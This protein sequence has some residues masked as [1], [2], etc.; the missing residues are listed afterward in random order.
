MSTITLEAALHPAQEAVWTSN[1]RF[2]VV[3]C[4]RRFGKT[5]LAVLEVIHHAVNLHGAEVWWVSPTHDQSDIA[6]RMFKAAV[7]Q[8]LVVLNETKRLAIFRHNGSRV[9]FK[10]A[11]RD[12]N[13]RGE[14]LTFLVLDEAAFIK[15][16]AW[17]GSLLPS[18][19]DRRGSALLIGTFDG[20]ENWFYVEYMR[21]QDPS[22]LA[23]DSWRFPTSANPYISLDEIEAARKRMPSDQFAQEFLADPLAKRGAVFPGHYVQAAIE[24]GRPVK[25][26]PA[27]PKYAGL[28]WGYAN[29]TVFEVCQESTESHVDWIDERSWVT[30]QL[31]VRV[32]VIVELVK[33]YNVLTV[34]ADAAGASE[35]AKLLAA[36]EAEGL[37]TTLLRVPFGKKVGQKGETL[38]EAGI[39]TRRWYL[40]NDLESLGMK[41]PE[42]QRTTLLYH[43]KE[44]KLSSGRTVSTE[45]IEKHDDHP[46]DAA[47]CFYASRRHQIIEE[48]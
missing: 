14:G 28:D 15:E 43:Y 42:L 8:S 44:V 45:D 47:T 3:G 31:D 18:L 7:P 35:N 46:V 19:A 17:Y 40:E 22:E 26:N 34:Y 1:A 10:S 27:L 5:H 38:K 6:W 11:D 20:I 29:A 32:R 30:T 25:A 2:R 23:V 21:G 37:E 33:K 24:R 4:G 12:K 9:Q 41:V 39:K 13:L 48:R 36:M 16:D